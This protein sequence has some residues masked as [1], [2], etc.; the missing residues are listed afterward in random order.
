MYSISLSVLL[1]SM[2]TFALQAQDE[3]KVDALYENNCAGCHGEKLGGGI[4]PSLVDDEWK[5]DTSASSLA[6]VIKD[7]VATTEMMA[8]GEIL[9]DAQIRA[10]VIYIKEMEFAR[11]ADALAARMKPK[12]GVFD[13][14]D[15]KFKLTQLV[16]SDG[17]LWSVNFLPDGQMI[18]TKKDKNLYF[19]EDGELVEITGIPE[20]WVKGQGGLLSVAPHP[21]YAKNGWVY[22]SLSASAGY[23]IDDKDSGM[24]KV[25]R[26]RIK[27]NKWVDNQ[28]IFE[29]KPE[30]HSEQGGHFGSRFVFDQGYV[31][32]GI[33]DRR[34][35]DRV[36]DITKPN[37]SLY[38]LHD[39]GR[40]PADNPFVG[41]ENAY[42]GIWSYGHRNPQGLAM[43]P[44]TGD[45]YNSEHGPRGGDE[46]NLIK[47]GANYG[48]PIITY[49]M[50]YNGTPWSDITEKEGMEQPLHYWTPS[51]AV[52]AMVF[53][54]GEQFP[55]WKN[56]LIVGSLKKEELWR[57]TLDG[58][59]LVSK[60]LIMKGQG[61]LRSVRVGPDGAIYFTMDADDEDRG[62]IYKMEVVE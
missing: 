15:H 34:Y 18:V 24:T 50:N 56:D 39:D 21:D 20:V 62:G 55:A 35:E 53:Y 38:R 49:G 61:R 6:A 36:Q 43:H 59:K 28:V 57:L 31:Y 44:V 54:T 4:A 12:G 40:I 9:N 37:G 45:L 27:D 14:A 1:I 22:L 51:I 10:L 41:V 30:D 60:E 16:K 25:V 11:K 2:S 8:F 29:A 33:G 17:R 32:F 5:H 52:S 26:G 23:K 13:T 3:V 42:E 58:D 47:K 46:I 19:V 48:W 7:G